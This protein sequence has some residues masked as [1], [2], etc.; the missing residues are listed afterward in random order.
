M[1]YGPC[2]ECGGEMMGCEYPYGDPLRYD[3]I[4]EWRCMSCGVRVGRWSGKRLQPGEAEPPF[5][6]VRA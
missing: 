5:G 6:R 2:P 1:A 4:S 3:G